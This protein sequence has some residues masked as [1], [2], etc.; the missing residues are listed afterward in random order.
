MIWHICRIFRK[1]YR[2]FRWLPIIWRDYE[3]S[4]VF[5]FKILQFK[6][7]LMEEFYRSS[8]AISANSL[9]VASQVHTCRLLCKRIVEDDYTTPWDELNK[10]VFARFNWH[11]LNDNDE[12]ELEKK[13]IMWAIEREDQQRNQDIQYLC[14][15]IQ[16][17]IWCW[18]D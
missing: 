8:N 15:I 1:I 9:D 2:L 16:K 17:H 4:Y 18:W 13:R 10:P 6:F 14:R 3:W 12:T 11:G 5:L 7:K